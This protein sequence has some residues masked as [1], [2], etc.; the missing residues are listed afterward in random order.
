MLGVDSGFWIKTSVKD[1][2]LKS[3]NTNIL[4]KGFSDCPETS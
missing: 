2:Y 1:W 4:L 3:D